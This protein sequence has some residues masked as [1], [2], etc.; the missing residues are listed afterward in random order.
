MRAVDAAARKA[1][2]W[3]QRHGKSSAT[4]LPKM[5]DHLACAGRAGRSLDKMPPVQPR[6]C[7]FFAP[8]PAVKRLLGASRHLRAIPPV[9]GRMRDP[10]DANDH[11]DLSL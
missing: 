4:T 7:R 9:P 11:W 6:L 10:A 1:S 3:W 5:Q 2:T 8:A